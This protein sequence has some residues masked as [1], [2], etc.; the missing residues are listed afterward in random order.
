MKSR[1]LQ[2]LVAIVCLSILWVSL[3][4]A[5]REDVTKSFDVKKGGQLV[6]HCEEAGADIYIRVWSKSEVLVKVS[7]LHEDELEDLEIEKSGNTVNVEYYGRGWK[8]SSHARFVIN[9]PSQFDLELRTA[10]GDIE[11]D[12][13]IKGIVEAATSG[14]DIE[15]Q[16]VDGNIDLATSGG[17]VTAGTVMGDADMRTSG[18]D[19]EIINVEGEADV[20]TSGGDINVGTVGKELNAK[21][22]GGDIEIGDVGGYADVATA[23]GDVIV[24][25]VSGAADL[26]TAGG[27]I[28]LASASGDVEAKTAGGDIELRDITGSIR[29]QTAGG[30]VV[31]ELIPGG[32]KAS[33]LE[34]AGGDIELYIP[35]DAKVMIDAR[36]RIRGWDREHDDHYDDYEI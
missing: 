29:A 1:K 33:S 2:I 26:K 15:V 21:T 19:I 14:G 6:V 24:G 36:I 10:G 16:D 20:K 35:G 5:G 9:V 18:G 23:G 28:E 13:K 34:T 17:D 31:G 12:D 3:A 8:R 22:A 4:L 32:R 27:D 25:R 11:V 30:D 7:G